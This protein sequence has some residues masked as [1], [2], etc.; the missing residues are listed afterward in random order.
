MKLK[1]QDQNGILA[2]K[3]KTN[4]MIIIGNGCDFQ[5]YDI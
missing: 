4:S 1:V 5:S 3:T 2:K